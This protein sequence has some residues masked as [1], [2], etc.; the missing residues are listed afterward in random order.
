MPHSLLFPVASSLSPSL[1]LIS[2][3]RKEIYSR[4]TPGQRDM[5]NRAISVLRETQEDPRLTLLERRVK[6]CCV[7]SGGEPDRLPTSFPVLTLRKNVR[8]SHMVAW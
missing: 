6:I 7:L 8:F 4:E 3:Q 2:S 5:Q 1:A